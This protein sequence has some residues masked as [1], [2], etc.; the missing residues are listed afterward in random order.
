[1]PSSSRSLHGG[2]SPLKFV[3]ALAY[4]LPVVATEHAGALIEDARAGEHYL[5]AA[6]ADGFADALGPVL[7]DPARGPPARRR[8]TRTRRRHY[9]VA[10]LAEWL[11]E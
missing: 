4:A 7:T 6:D 3:E 10:A 8:G 9:S 1:M 2:G 5:G 11:A